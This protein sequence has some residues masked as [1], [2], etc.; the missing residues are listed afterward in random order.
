MND[1]TESTTADGV[2]QR[3][4]SSHIDVA[5]VEGNGDDVFLKVGGD[6]VLTDE[7]GA[8]LLAKEIEETLEAGS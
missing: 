3:L 7:S 8:R 1:A 4:G 5:C 6:V 2:A